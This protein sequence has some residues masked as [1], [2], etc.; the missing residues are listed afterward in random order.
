MAELTMAELTMAELIDA[1]EGIED[2]T[3]ILTRNHARN[4]DCGLIWV[5]L[6]LGG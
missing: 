6:G 3:G 1:E 4:S 2:I 5:K